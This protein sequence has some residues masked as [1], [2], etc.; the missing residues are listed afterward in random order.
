MKTQLLD[1]DFFGDVVK[2]YTD[3]MVCLTDLVFSGNKYRWST[4]RKTF[5]LS[6]FLQSKELADYK[7]EASDLW[8]VPIDQMVKT[9]GKGPASRTYGHISIAILL[10][11]A[12]SPRYHAKIHKEFIE[13]KLLEYRELGGDEFKIL[14]STI[15]Q[16]LPSPS[17]NDRG[18]WINIAKMIKDRCA[19]VTPEGQETWNQLEADALVQKRRYNMEAQLVKLLQLGVVRDWD[20]FKELVA[21]V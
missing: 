20:H 2:A 12:I 10:C 17:G 3:G 9:V 14:N 5:Q 6:S 1:V 21:K 11:E 13:G 7:V 16:F 19:L 8:N 4:G 18:R 15:S